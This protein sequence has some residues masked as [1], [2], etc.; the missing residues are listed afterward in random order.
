MG[1]I[2]IESEADVGK[3]TEDLEMSVPCWG[4]GQ[5]AVYECGGRGLC[6]ASSW[7]LAESGGAP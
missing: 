5:P 3:V 7:A 6:D 2:S 1:P 4:Y